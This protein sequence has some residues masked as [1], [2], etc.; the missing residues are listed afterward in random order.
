V[1]CDMCSNWYHGACVG[2]KAR[3][4]KKLKSFTCPQCQAAKE[5]RE[6]F[7]FCRT[8]YDESQFYIGC[9]KC[10]DWFHGRC[11]GLLPSEGDDIDDYVCPR[12][13]P[14]SAINR[15]NFT[16]LADGGYTELRRLFQLIKNN[17]NARPFIEPVDPDEVPNYYKVIKEPMDLQTMENRLESRHYGRLCDFTGDVIVVLDNCKYFN[18][19]GTRLA[20]CG[21]NLEAFFRAELKKLRLKL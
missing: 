17:K 1:G 6:L 14:N 8:E 11:V 19:P 3:Q 2:V 21:V 4:S 13:E 18:P 10:E 15:P 5:N 12:C 20:T 16:P 9:D 7:C